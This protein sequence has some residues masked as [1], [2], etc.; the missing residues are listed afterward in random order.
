MK[1]NSNF[2]KTAAPVIVLV[3]ICLLVT[4]ALAATYGVAHPISEKNKIK[5][6]NETRKELLSKAD[7]F[8]AH[9]GKL[10][11]SKDGKVS[12]KDCYVADNKEGVVMTVV[13]K[14]FGGDLT[15]MIGVSKDGKITGV[16]VTEHADTPGLGT[17][18]H[19]PEHLSQYKGLAEITEISCK[20]DKKVTHITGAT[21]SSN[22]VHYGVY[23]A[24]KQYKDMGGVK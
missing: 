22:A 21:I 24:M 13:T 19:T 3:A 20:D 4:A 14:S 17:K 12:V 2:K 8:T 7:K 9:K 6:A 5:R 18:A 23:A 1:N 10:W 15:E 16:K 11:A